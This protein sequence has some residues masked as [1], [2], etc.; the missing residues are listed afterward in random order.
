MK[1]RN[2]MFLA[3]AAAVVLAGAGST[4]ALAKDSLVIAEEGDC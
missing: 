4:T 1:R 2:V 3:A